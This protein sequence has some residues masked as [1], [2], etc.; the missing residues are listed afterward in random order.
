MCDI[1]HRGVAE[2]SEMAACRRRLDVPFETVHLNER[3]APLRELTDGRTPCVVA[4]HDD[5][6]MSVLLGSDELGACGGSVESFE[7]EILRRL[8]A[9]VA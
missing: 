9:S 8:D 6:E 3:D 1:T 2:K 4:I 7:A 5:G